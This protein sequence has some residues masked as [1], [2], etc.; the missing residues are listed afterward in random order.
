MSKIV[1]LTAMAL[2]DHEPSDKDF[3]NFF[4]AKWTKGQI[5]YEWN[6]VFRLY[7]L[8]EMKEV[9]IKTPPRFQDFEE[10]LISEFKKNFKHT[11]YTNSEKYDKSTQY[12]NNMKRQIAYA[13]RTA[14]RVVFVDC[15]AKVYPGLTNYYVVKYIRL[16]KLGLDITNPYQEICEIEQIPY[17]TYIKL[18]YIFGYEELEEYVV[19]H[20]GNKFESMSKMAAHYGRS[21][22]YINSRLKEGYTLEQALTLPKYAKRP[23]PEGNAINKKQICD[24]KGISY[25][26][27]TAMC[28]A[29]GIS[30]SVYRSRIA[31]GLSVKDALTLECKKGKA[32]PMAM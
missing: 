31:R 12:L 14:Y 13:A 15:A 11:V 17:K 2:K 3:E 1:E 7:G 20:L 21:A 25:S 23:A 6:R 10:T 5:K 30:L 22:A 27:F 32:L 4:K 29:Y 24:H 18:R 16:R 19:D 9:Y 28:D 8:H 26:S